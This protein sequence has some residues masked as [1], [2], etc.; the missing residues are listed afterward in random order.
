[1]KNYYE[2]LN[3]ANVNMGSLLI[4]KCIENTEG[5]TLLPDGRLR[6]SVY[7]QQKPIQNGKMSIRGGVFYIPSKKIF[8][9]DKVAYDGTGGNFGGGETV[10]GNITL[11]T[12]IFCNDDGGGG[13]PE[14]AY[15]R[16]FGKQKFDKL[17][18][19]IQIFSRGICNEHTNEILNRP[20]TQL[21]DLLHS[22]NCDKSIAKYML[23]NSSTY[24]QIKFAIKEFVISTA[25]KTRGFDSILCYNPRI[26]Q[27]TELFYLKQEYYPTASGFEL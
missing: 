4:Q 26:A 6:L 18:Y 27:F 24:R 23:T 3:E 17:Y 20:T 21:E 16:L 10:T 13:G 7:R 1:M 19:D 9:L 5:A 12:P 2:F 25:I 22:Y 8:E 11:K 14:I 15:K